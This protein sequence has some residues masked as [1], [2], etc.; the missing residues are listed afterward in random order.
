MSNTVQSTIHAWLQKA[1]SASLPIVST[2]STV[3]RRRIIIHDSDDEDITKAACDT[4]VA[5]TSTN[6]EPHFQSGMTTARQFPGGHV[7]VVRIASN[8]LLDTD[9][10]STATNTGPPHPPGT[11]EVEVAPAIKKTVRVSDEDA[12]ATN[13]ESFRGASAITKDDTDA[14]N[15]SPRPADMPVLLTDS[16][17]SDDDAIDVTALSSTAT[18][19]EP[20]HS[21]GTPNVVV[22]PFIKKTARASDEDANAINTES[23]RPSSMS[24]VVAITKDD[25]DIS[26]TL[27]SPRPADMPVLLTD[28]GD[29]DDDAI[30]VTALICDEDLASKNDSD[31]EEAPAEVVVVASR[32]ADVAATAQTKTLLQSGITRTRLYHGGHVSVV[33]VP[34]PAVAAIAQ[35]KLLFQSGITTTRLYHG[36]HVSIVRETPADMPMLIT[37]SGESDDDAVDTTAPIGDEDLASSNDSDHDEALSLCTASRSTSAPMSA[38]TSTQFQQRGCVHVHANPVV[39][40]EANAIAVDPGSVPIDPL[41]LWKALPKAPCQFLDMS[42][43]HQSD[44]EDQESYYD[45]DSSELSEGFISSEDDGVPAKHRKMISKLLPLT[46]R[47]LERVKREAGKRRR[48]AP[49][50]APHSP[51]TLASMHLQASEVGMPGNI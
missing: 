31:L 14:T 33:R 18:N 32:D 6:T 42:A 5:A 34:H 37:D 17:E 19:T 44:G 36:G 30:D 11:P 43:K 12:N 27:T 41:N 4:N 26:A 50:S 22:T 15:T 24:D 46:M 3:R 21:T 38:P 51:C 45:S 20:P 49:T 8:S 47:A 25:T 10:D 40:K 48:P 39:I 2:P 23:F 9:V 7:I 29:S 16:G 1:P 35:T 13:T 28:S